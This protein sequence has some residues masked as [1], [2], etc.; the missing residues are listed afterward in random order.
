MRFAISLLTIICI[1]SVVGTVVQQNQPITNYVNQFGPFWFEVFSVFD[2]NQVYNAGWFMVIMAFLVVSTTFCLVRTT[3]KLIKDMRSYKEHVREN[4]LRSFPHHAESASAQTPQELASRLETLLGARGFRLRKRES[5]GSVLLA[6]KAGA[7]NRLGYI[8]THAA[9]V[10][11]CIGGLLDSELPVRIISWLGGKTPIVENM[12]IADVPEQGRL[13]LGNPSFR[14]NALVPEGG[15]TRYGIVRSG[16]GALLQPLPFEIT[17]DKFIVE[18]YATGMPRLFA[19]EVKVRDLETGESFPAR[20]EVNHPL[21]YKGVTVYQSSFDDG[22]SEL[23]LKGWP[24]QGPVAR[25]FDVQGVVGM[26]TELLQGDKQIPYTIEFSAFRPINVENLS[27][28]QM[29]SPEAPR[30]T[31][32]VRGEISMLAGPAARLGGNKGLRNVGPSVQYKLRDASGQAREYH[33]YM[34]PVELDG[35]RVYLAGMRENPNET[36]RYLRIPADADDRVDEFMFLRAALQDP[37]AREEAARRFAKA[38]APAGASVPLL[39][40]LEESSRRALDTFAA[41]GLQAIAR[42]LEETVPAEEQ[43]RAAEVVVR[44]LGGLMG[45]LRGVMREQRGLPVLPTEGDAALQASAWLQLAVAALSDLAFYPAPVWLGLED[46]KHVQAS[47]FQVSK[48]PGKYTVYIG[49]LLLTLG[50]F[51]MF[52]IRER[53]IWVWV[54]PDGQ[55]SRLLMAMTSQRRTLDFDREFEQLRNDAQA[56]AAP[57]SGRSGV[58]S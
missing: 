19:S 27:Q 14:S 46:F 4:S 42:F 30:I 47:V 24:L 5:D 54:R 32:R 38:S 51:A 43:A 28:A 9:I 29:V 7:G 56:V 45:E 3:P 2:L 15:S 55:G 23:T 18:Y 37:L 40:Q 50:I 21:V 36:F 16:E 22:G 17:L 20:I 13:P 1:A 44:L 33:N 34:F 8:F 58:T 10:I 25:S 35:A 52:Y 12:L 11:I 6:G 48:A 31:E 39:A 49:C 53:R 57:T 41:G 26:S